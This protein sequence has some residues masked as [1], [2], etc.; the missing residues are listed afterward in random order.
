MCEECNDLKYIR[1]D[2]TALCEEHRLEE[3]S[4]TARI[5]TSN[6]HFGMLSKIAEMDR[7]MKENEE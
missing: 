5:A 3:L 7:K 2:P 6:F 1:K 4:E